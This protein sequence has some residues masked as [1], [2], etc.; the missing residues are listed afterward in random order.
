[1]S[2]AAALWFVLGWFLAGFVNGIT[3]FG[4]AMVAMP[5]VTQG[6]DITLAVPACS[7]MVWVVS[8]EQGWRYRGHTDWRRIRPVLIGA[9]PGALIGFMV[10]RHL[11]PQHLKL[12]LGM[13]LL[14]YACWGLFL[15]DG[16]A[17]VIGAVWGYAAGLLST[18]FGSAFSF[19][20][21]PLAVYASLSGW[22]KV[23]SKAGLAMTFIVTSSLMVF[24]QVFAGAHNAITLTAMLI[25]VPAAI[26]GSW[27]GFLASR[28]M[29]DK[30]YRKLFFGFIACTGLNFFWQASRVLW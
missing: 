27:L 4:A 30:T 7:L 25:G 12:A 15:E 2:L 14:I 16:K 22:G 11:P 8:L 21:P 13:F 23:V 28:S 3:G 29:G 6:M 17:R 24:T 20:G 10:L 19:N 26:F 18:I 5:L 9:L 1:M